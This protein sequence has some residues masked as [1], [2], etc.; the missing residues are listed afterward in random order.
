MGVFHGYPYTNFHDLNLDWVLDTVKELRT[1]LTR[2][3][4]LNTIK[5]ANPFQWN[6]TSQYSQNTLV[7]DPQD[8]TAYLSVQPVPSGVQITNTD[9]WTPVFT[10][11]NFT[12]ALKTAITRQ[13]PQQENGAAATQEIPAN[14]IF[15]VGDTLCT[16]SGTIPVTSLVVIGSNCSQVSVVELIT[17]IQQS[18]TAEQTAR[19]QADQQLQQGITAE[20]TAREQADQQLQ[21]GIDNSQTFAN[22]TKYGAKGDGTTDDTAAFAAASETGLPLYIPAGTYVLNGATIKSAFFAGGILSGTFTIQGIENPARVQ[23]FETAANITAPFDAIPVGYPEWYGAVTGTPAE[24]C[25]AALE[26]CIAVHPKTQLSSG[27]YYVSRTINISTSNRVVEGVVEAGW[28][29][30]DATAT[31]SVIRSTSTSAAIVMVGTASKP[32]NHN[33]FVQKVI[34]RSVVFDRQAVKTYSD[35]STG[36]VWQY[37]LRCWMEHCMVMHNATGVR[38]T[39]NILLKI[40]D[41]YIFT[42]TWA[43]N[44]TART[45]RGVQLDNSQDISVAGGNASIY[46]LDTTMATGGDTVYTNSFAISSGGSMGTNDI[47]IDNCDAQGFAYGLYISGDGATQQNNVHLVNSMFDLVTNIGVYLNAVTGC[48]MDVRGCFF[49][50]G[51]GATT[52]GFF[53]I[54]CTGAITVAECD[55]IG[56]GNATYTAISLEN[57]QGVRC[58]NNRLYGCASPHVLTG[59]KV[60]QTADIIH[61]DTSTGN[62]ATHMTNCARCKDASIISNA[63]D[64]TYNAGLYCT[65]CSRC[66]CDVSGY[67]NDAIASGTRQFVYANSGWASSI[68]VANSAVYVY[69]FFTD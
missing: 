23:I 51:E 3:V 21:Q 50:P 60:C 48:T 1:Q 62:P 46:L 56:Y 10:L 30:E 33:Q 32:S 58:E 19:E 42:E 47:M 55:F 64:V 13:I 12:D 65:G 49:S 37:T 69:G 35:T 68:G 29:Y 57:S 53:A 9:Y 15:F 43:A 28:T 39:G 7:M 41:C 34:L 26:K 16:N 27:V 25:A 20:Q 14:S 44:D 18:I 2:F 22:V 59:C 63:A 36:I 31:G 66:T 8:G 4:A 67:N 61:T 6:I 11:Q 52:R 38:I 17:T 45:I 24:D 54:G 5:Y 40:C